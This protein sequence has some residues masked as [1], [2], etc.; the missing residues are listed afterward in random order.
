[1]E[2]LRYWVGFNR[3]KGI[4]PARLRA[5]IDHFGDLETAW[6][7][8]PPALQRAGL[9]QRTLESLLSTRAN[10]DLDA[11]LRAIERAGAHVLTLDDPDYPELL[12]H[13]SDPPTL[14]YVRGRLTRTDRLAVAIVGTRGATTYGK[15]IAGEFAAALAGRGITIVSGLARGIDSTAHRAALD[16]GGRTIAVL[17]C[18]IDRI[19]PSE[20]RDLAEA[21]AERGALITE[22][23]IG[24][25]PERR[26]FAPRNRIVSG[27][28]LGVLVVEASEKSGALITADRA[29]EQG[30]EVFAVPGNVHSPASLGA[31]ALI[32]A[33]AKMTTRAEDI[34]EE[35]RLDGLPAR[36]VPAV[37]PR[38]PAG[39]S[40]V[41]SAPTPEPA[42]TLSE[43]APETTQTETLVLRHLSAGASH[44]DDLAQR[45]G[46]PVRHVS[47]ALTTLELK[48]LV[49][50]VGVLEYVA[51]G[52]D[53]NPNS[54]KSQRK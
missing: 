11:E 17:P 53:P 34:L 43:A 37:P 26:H 20:H 49:R 10:C 16:S 12:R 22:L 44:V 52:P 7:A 30:R 24:E 13:I 42:P 23:P 19:Y 51:A 32:Q 41:D 18:G 31:N 4:G 9:D 33:G 54:Q 47:G 40:A 39:V 21:I 50:Q 27:L 45:S 8:S 48:G 14:L 6:K 46:L 5:L 2:S 28:C 35:L 36:P 15:T 29:L 38:R 1:M 25:P 3:T